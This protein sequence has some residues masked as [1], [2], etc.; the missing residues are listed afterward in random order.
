MHDPYEI[1]HLKLAQKNIEMQA[2]KQQLFSLDKFAAFGAAS[3]A[4]FG[5]L[6]AVMQIAADGADPLRHHSS[7]MA[8][9]E[10]ENQ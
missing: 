7:I 3:R 4:V 2:G 8:E 5:G 10:I 6:L 9:S 1:R